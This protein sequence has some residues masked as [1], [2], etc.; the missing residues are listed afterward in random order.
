MSQITSTTFLLL[1][2]LLLFAVPAAVLLKRLGGY[3][4]WAMLWYV[5]V[6]AML[7]RGCWSSRPEQAARRN[8]AAMVQRFVV[9]LT[10]GLLFLQLVGCAR[11]SAPV[12]R[13]AKAGAKVQSFAA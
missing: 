6:L 8:L 1:A 11:S 4:A 2:C 9:V 12:Q 10:A 3:P 7:G 5:P 13:W